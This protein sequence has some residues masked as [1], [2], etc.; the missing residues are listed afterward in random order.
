[1]LVICQYCEAP[2]KSNVQHRS[3][4]Q[5]VFLEHDLFK[6]KNKATCEVCPKFPRKVPK[7]CF[8]DTRREETPSTETPAQ[9]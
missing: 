4:K 3:F 9:V 6:S 2:T 1:M 5:G 8:K 7:Y